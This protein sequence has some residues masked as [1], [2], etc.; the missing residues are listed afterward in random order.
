MEAYLYSAIEQEAYLNQLDNNYLKN[1]KPY[2]VFNYIKNKIDFRL[3][4]NNIGQ[5]II[6]NE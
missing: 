1:R 3:D 6:N 4:S 5:I 2:T